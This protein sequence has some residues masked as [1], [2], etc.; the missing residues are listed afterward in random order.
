M[1]MRILFPA[2]FFLSAYS[3][4]QV[5]IV[6]YETLEKEF[7]TQG[8]TTTIINF[9]ATSSK[10]SIEEFPYF[11]LAQEEYK[12]QKV[13]FVYV[14]L[15]FSPLKERVENFVEKKGLKGKTYI[16]KD[17]RNIW[18]NKIDTDWGGQIPFTLLVKRNGDTVGHDVKFI[19]FNELN[20][21]IKN[22]HN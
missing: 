10:S 11:I 6:N 2:L 17:D 5:S 1:K 12:N 4:G 8:D 16:L 9:W 18:V 7:D 13:K 22:N 21:F 15:D 20:I 19:S 3:F 14:S